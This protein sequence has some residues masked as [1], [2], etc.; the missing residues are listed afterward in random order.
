MKKKVIKELKELEGEARGIHLKNDAEY[1][2]KEKGKEGLEEVEKKLSLWGVNIRYSE[3]QNLK[4]YPAGW[5]SLSLLAT[6]EVFDWEKEDIRKMCEFAAGVSFAVRLYLKYF[7][8]VSKLLEKVSRMWREYWSFG[9]VEVRNFKEEEKEL[10]LVVSDF[11]CHPI[12]C[13]C[14]KGYLEG[15]G[16]MVTKSKVKVEGECESEK[17]VHKYHVKWR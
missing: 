10:E 17:G 14:M 9:E 15:L 12:Y 8:S 7:Y 1:I 2:L 16:R 6:K 11:N 3:I 5:R 13:E 4:F